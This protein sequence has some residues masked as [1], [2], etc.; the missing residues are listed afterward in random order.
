MILNDTILDYICKLLVGS[1]DS[2]LN[3]LNDNSL[4][5]IKK[6]IEEVLPPSEYKEITK[7]FKTLREKSKYN[8]IKLVLEQYQKTST[9]SNII[10]KFLD[11][12]YKR[13]EKI[14]EL[15]NRELKKEGISIYKDY[16]Y[17]TWEV[18]ASLSLSEDTRNYIADVILNKIIYKKSNEFA[19]RF[20]KS[21]GSKKYQIS[22]FQ[23]KIIEYVHAQVDES[24]DSA[25]M[26]LVIRKMLD[27][28]FLDKDEQKRAILSL[29]K[30]LKNDGYFLESK[31]A[32]FE[33]I[34]LDGELSHR[35]KE[36]VYLTMEYICDRFKESVEND[37]WRNIYLDEKMTQAKNET[38]VQP[39]FKTIA[40]IYCLQKDL[41]ITAEALTPRGPVDFKFSRG[42]KKISLV[43]IK[44]SYYK[45]LAH[46]IKVQI[47]KYMSTSASDKCILLVIDVS[48][49][50]F[51][52]GEKPKLDK[53]I[54][55]SPYKI[56]L[57]V[58]NASPR[59]KESGSKAES[60]DED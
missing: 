22:D 32:S 58:V 11:K 49:G 46:T 1:R 34:P 43:E 26:S 18:D 3:Y 19:E 8:L 4:P 45:K 5:K 41:D 56:K 48:D 50:S 52:I 33:V 47:P 9:I 14:V 31:G 51:M 35:N 13:V 21:I 37:L 30:L 57:V 7:K 27:L 55:A 16:E 60:F 54:E 39:L 23:D 53:L 38:K 40:S 12:D 17:N 20:F 10:K 15:I 2:K 6:N 44:M 36:D 29:K 59:G 24:N 25:N 42:F 28:R